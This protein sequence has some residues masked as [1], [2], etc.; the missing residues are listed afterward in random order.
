MLLASP[1][2]ARAQSTTELA[3]SPA[4]AWMDGRGGLQVR[5]SGS[6]T[7][8]FAP[9]AYPAHAGLEL[10]QGSSYSAVGAAGRAL[11][12]GPAVDAPA[13][14][15]SRATSVFQVGALKVTERV[16]LDSGQAAV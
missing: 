3:S 12:S 4:S 8:Q 5:L 16:L 14:G 9:D 11:L 13:A 1:A 15:T 2:P 10:V 6:G 7:G